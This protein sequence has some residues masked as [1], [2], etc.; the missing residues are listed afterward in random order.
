ME[1]AVASIYIQVNVNCPNCNEWIDLLDDSL[2]TEVEKSDIMIISFQDE[3]GCKDAEI[4]VKCPEC[5]KKFIVT[6]IEW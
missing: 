1:N 5:E 6:E 4:E 2:D 3:W